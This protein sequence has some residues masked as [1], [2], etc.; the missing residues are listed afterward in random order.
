MKR[1]V[2][3]TIAAIS[4]SCSA[5]ANQVAAPTSPEDVEQTLNKVVPLP[6]NKLFFATLVLELIKNDGGPPGQAQ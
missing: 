6:A 2:L 3:T 4:L 1:F 5:Y